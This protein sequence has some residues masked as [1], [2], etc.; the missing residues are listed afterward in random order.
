MLFVDYRTEKQ[1]N[2]LFVC[3]VADDNINYL[4]KL[5]MFYSTEDWILIYNLHGLKGYP[6]MVLKINYRVSA[7]GM[8]FAQS[9]LTF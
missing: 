8:T 4:H 7:K 9:E 6:G 2:I 1:L 3:M 5:I